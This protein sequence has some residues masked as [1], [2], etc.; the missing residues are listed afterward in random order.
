MSNTVEVPREELEKL[1][2]EAAL[3]RY[4]VR[5]RLLEGFIR[6]D[7]HIECIEG[8]AKVKIHDAQIVTPYGTATM[9]MNVDGGHIVHFQTGSTFKLGHEVQLKIS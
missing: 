6:Q 9:H 7:T 8:E 3:W 4:H 1:Q 2:Q 5:Q